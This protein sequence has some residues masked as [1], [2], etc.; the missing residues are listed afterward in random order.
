MVVSYE[1]GTPAQRVQEALACRGLSNDGFDSTPKM[2]VLGR[3]Y[4]QGPAVG[5]MVPLA[6]CDLRA[7]ILAIIGEGVNSLETPA[8]PERSR[9][10]GGRGERLSRTGVPEKRPPPGTLP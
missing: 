1:R 10:I 9:F 6:T 3:S 8:P 7:M 5:R 2:E 4:T